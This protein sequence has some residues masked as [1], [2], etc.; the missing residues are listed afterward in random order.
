M[1]RSGFNY[2]AASFLSSASRSGFW[3]QATLVSD[4]AHR[5]YRIHNEPR[6]LQPAPARSSVET[7]VG[8]DVDAGRVIDDRAAA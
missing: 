1:V 4:G 5:Q 6:G 7:G 3:S 8:S 2:T